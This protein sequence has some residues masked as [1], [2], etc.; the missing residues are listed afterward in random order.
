MFISRFII[1]QNVI[2]NEL[3]VLNNILNQQRQLK[4][5]LLLY[6]E[7]ISDGI[8]QASDP[9]DLD[10]LISCL[11]TIKESF[12]N[13]KSN[14]NQIIELKN[15]LENI[16]KF[17]Y[18][19]TSYFEK[20]NTKYL[21]VFEKISE[22]N[23]FYY[24]FMESILKYVKIEFPENIPTI[25]EI[26]Y[27]VNQNTESIV[28]KKISEYSTQ[29]P[30]SNTEN[31]TN[32]IM[33]ENLKLLNI[34]SIDNHSP[35]SKD[36]TNTLNNNVI[37]EITSS[38]IEENID[39][40]NITNEESIFPNN[41][42]SN[43]VTSSV[44]EEN[45]DNLNIV[46]DE[47]SILPNNDFLDEVAS[48]IIEENID[49][50][51]ITNEESIFPNNDFSNEVT[52]SVIEENIDNLN[53]VN[54]EESILPNNDFLDE[55]VSSIIEE[56]IDNLNI[57]NDEESIL[58]NNDILNEDTSSIITE[59]NNISYEIPNIKTAPIT[60]KIDTDPFKKIAN[61]ISVSE[62]KKD[63][64][65]DE[66]KIENP[67]FTNVDTN[68]TNSNNIIKKINTSYLRREKK[69]EPEFSNNFL[70]RTLVIS[71]KNNTVILPYSVAEL[72]EC[73]SNNPEKYSSIQDIIDK[74]YTISLDIYKNA[75]IARFKEAFNLARHKENLSFMDSINLAN[76]L[77]FNSNLN[78]AVITACKTLDELDIYLSCLEDDDL[79][80]FKFFKI[81]YI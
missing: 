74:E 21:K 75:P 29:T 76:E 42:F 72:E 68:K 4:K 16:T 6:L 61:K 62:I 31:V 35:S 70:E 50:L 73:F 18:L 58:P 56:N 11:D 38:I 43:E 48:S 77:L 30:I 65:L 33:T 41:D 23:I 78:P 45:I 20:Y 44:I 12:E 25:S 27:D 7:K 17:D 51:N 13:I 24:S 9:Q 66:H 47:E 53:I 69:N 54:D 28:Y 1:D 10:S 52:S 32:A 40:L 57:V 60:K 63:T 14:I 26:N 22:D 59:N 15:Y 36:I 2:N 79:E 46:N 64:I 81:K 5:T 8:Y 34:D 80:D 71:E 39:N 67:Q 37:D 49:N 19:E 3:K 55:V